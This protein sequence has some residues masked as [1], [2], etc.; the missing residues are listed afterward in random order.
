MK[1]FLYEVID[2]LYD[3][4]FITIKIHCHNDIDYTQKL[5]HVCLKIL[6]YCYTEEKMQFTHKHELY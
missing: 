6:T 1:L 3:I 2:R 5:L 4:Q